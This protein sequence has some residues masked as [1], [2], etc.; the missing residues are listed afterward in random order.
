MERAAGMMMISFN[1]IRSILLYLRCA[2]LLNHAGIRTV[3]KA[4]WLA[5]IPLELKHSYNQT[6]NETLN[7]YNGLT[8]TGLQTHTIHG[9]AFELIID[10]VMPVH[11]MGI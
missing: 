1:G 11:H 6:K 9:V 5:N 2:S 3:L 4:M 8:T 10:V 7:M